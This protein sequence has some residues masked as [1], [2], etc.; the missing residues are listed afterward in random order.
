MN[1]RTIFA[2]FSAALLITSCSMNE[3]PLLVESTAPFG[4][5]AF[6]KIK[7]EHYEPAFIAAIAEGK[8]QIKA[9]VDNPEEPDFS[10]T[11]EALEYC[12]ATLNKIQN[13]FF[14]LNEACTDS[15]M[16]Q[17]AEKVSPL[18][19]E[20]GM[21]IILNE[22]LFAKVKAVYDKRES[23]KLNEEQ[24]RLLEKTYKTFARNGANLPDDKKAE[25]AKIQEELSLATLKF[26]KNVLS[27]TN[28]YTL[29]ISDESQ[30]VG[31]PDYVKDAAASEAKARGKEGWV[32]TLNY[33][34]YSPFLKYSENREL[35]ETIWKAYNSKCIGG[36]FDNTQTI[37]DIVELRIR[38]A[39][40]LGYTTFADY[41]IEDKMA[42][43]PQ[44]VN[45]FLSD[46][47]QKSLPYAKKECAQIEEYAH[48]NGFEGVIMPWD[49]SYWSEKYQQEKYSLNEELLKPYF[50]LNSVQS[51]IFDLANRLYGLNF[52]ENKDIPV[53][54]PDVRAFEVTDENGRFMALLYLD[55]FPRE[56]KRGGAWMTSFREQSIIDGKENRPFVSLVTNFTKPTETTPALLTFDEFTTI[57]HEFGHALHGML[58]EG[59]YSSLTG[60]NVER[61][62]VELPSQIMENW[63]YEPEYLQT[64]AK[65]YQTG[66]VIP[67][68]FI[69][70]IVAAKNYLSGYFNV[71]QLDFGITDMAWHTLTSLPDLSVVEF[72]QNV[73]K[74]ASILPAVD[75]VVFSPS[76]NH[77]FSGGYSA[78]YY[79]YKWAEVLEA[80]AFSLFKEKGIFNRE[81]AN[82]FREKVLSRGN[83]VDANVLFRDFRG[84]DPQPEALLEKLGLK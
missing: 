19:T 14:N 8:E 65:H 42:K 10:N 57:L 12:V 75:G 32:F 59:T 17:T 28:A 76:F 68:E 53:Y 64:F 56:S 51:A 61:D 55:F 27:A 79:S 15:L 40:L 31:L 52:K 1:N 73:L 80:D 16:Q 33:P 35:R 7:T 36:D 74:E 71:R 11:I 60:T 21:S 63:A 26:G 82:E 50:E 20:Y 47:L 81:L 78:G 5:P 9:I 66:E 39:N 44:T 25:F 2:A 38:E 62:F 69:D 83:I 4:A 70:R 13:L 48:S 18:I 46:L 77:I 37:R 23:L 3:N 6:D 34:S 29:E 30:L 84:R 67:Q 58:A 45:N 54:H 24:A 22:E 43:N 49:F 41:Q 72:E